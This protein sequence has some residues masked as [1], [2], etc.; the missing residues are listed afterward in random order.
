M[1]TVVYCLTRLDPWDYRAVWH[2]QQTLRARCRVTRDNVLVLTQHPPVITLGYRRQG[3]Q[4]RLSAAELQQRGIEL[5]AV[6]RGGGATYHG[7]GQLVAYPIFSSLLQRAGIRR[8]VACLEEVMCRVSHAF[9]VPA[10]RRPGL[11]G[12]WVGERKLGA[13]G[14][15]VRGGVSLHG[16][17]LNVNTDLRS[18]TY[19]V[20]CGMADMTVTSLQQECGAPISVAEVAEQT[21]L[22]FAQVFGVETEEM[23][24]EWGC[25]E[26]T[27]GMG[28]LADSQ[29][30]R[31]TQRA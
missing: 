19:I 18:F 31:A 3:E 4:V 10:A 14:I 11:P 2:L 6:E 17:A 16:F 26:R 12:V 20:P 25:L 5:V 28:P 9:D 29:P 30:S 15:A 1:R 7:P 24:Y 8:F 23:P 22:C 21:R 13:V 27:G